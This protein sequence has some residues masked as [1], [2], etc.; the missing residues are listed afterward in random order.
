MLRQGGIMRVILGFW[1]IVCSGVVGCSGRGGSDEPVSRVREAVVAIGPE[2][3]TE[4]PVLIQKDLGWNPSV[5]TNGSG[6][7]AATTIA[8]E[9]RGVR[10]DGNGQ[11]LDPI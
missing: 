1:V 10:V 8:G 2:I 9:V 3:G 6:F 5:G 7:L 11:V 4:T